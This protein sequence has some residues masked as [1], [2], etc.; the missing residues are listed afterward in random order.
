MTAAVSWASPAARTF[1]DPAS[2]KRILSSRKNVRF[3]NI[4]PGL[5]NGDGQRQLFGLCHGLLHLTGLTC[6]LRQGWLGARAWTAQ[7]RFNTSCACNL[8][9]TSYTSGVFG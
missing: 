4:S 8:S 3:C 7:A 2:P 5:G 9:G 1:P 6:G